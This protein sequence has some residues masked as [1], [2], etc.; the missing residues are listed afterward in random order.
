MAQD[1]EIL[2]F[3]PSHSAIAVDVRANVVTVS[4]LHIGMAHKEKVAGKG[5]ISNKEIISGLKKI[6]TEIGDKKENG[7]RSH[8]VLNG[9]IFE[10]LYCPKPSDV[11]IKPDEYQNKTHDKIREKYIEILRDLINTAK[12]NNCTIHYICGNHDDNKKFVHHLLDLD[13]ELN[14]G[15][16]K[17]KENF[18][19]HPVALRLG[20]ALFLHGDLALKYKKNVAARELNAQKYKIATKET[21][22]DLEENVIKNPFLNWRER[23]KNCAQQRVINVEKLANGVLHEPTEDTVN[24]SLFTRQNRIDKILSSLLE[25]NN[26]IGTFEAQGITKPASRICTGHTHDGYLAVSTSP[27]FLEKAPE[28]KETENNILFDN[29]GSGLSDRRIH[30]VQYLLDNDKVLKA[31]KIPAKI[32]TGRKIEPINVDFEVAPEGFLRF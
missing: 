24:K 22:E 17:G 31:E 9:D 23:I 12:E 11:D 13:K 6:I 3:D 1:K 25:D 16:E 10:M 5:C 14:N 20:T 21:E 29:T 7:K 30:A 19:F 27:E 4:D 32:I 26:L 2:T 15:V 28:L 18:L 8:L